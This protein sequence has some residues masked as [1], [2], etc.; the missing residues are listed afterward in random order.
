MSMNKEEHSAYKLEMRQKMPLEAKER[1]S[2]ERIKN[3]LVRGFQFSV[4]FSGGKDSTVVLDLMNRAYEEL[5]KD[6][7]DL[8]VFF[9][10]TG[11]EFP[12][13]KDFVKT[14]KN[15]T[16]LKPRR[17]FKQIIEKYGYP[18]VSKE[19][20]H[21][22]YQCRYTK[23]DYLRGKY[24]ST[25]Y[26]SLTSI[27]KKWRFLLDAPFDCSDVCRKYLKKDIANKHTQGKVVVIGTMAADSRLRKM[28]YLEHGCFASN[29]AQPQLRPIMFWLEEDIW[30]YLKIH[31]LPYSEI[32]DMGYKNTGCMFCGFGLQ[33][34]AQPNR[35]QKMSRTHP[36]QYKYVINTLKMGEVFDYM[37]V[38]YKWDSLCEFHNLTGGLL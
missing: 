29:L 32:Y 8:D 9:C 20:S 27:P 34:E 23:S 26:S 19:T 37:K 30:E 6:K 2:I 4:S 14:F 28:S 35:F 1:F 31:K 16:W 22:L 12:E 36:K 15:V 3:L 25:D 21:K 18:V 10:D 7:W 24:L 33:M 5:E 13:I 38:P 11:L 17:T